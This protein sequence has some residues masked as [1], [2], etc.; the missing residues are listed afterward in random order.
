[1]LLASAATPGLG[2]KAIAEQGTASGAPACTSCHGLHYE[3]NPVVEAPALAGLPAG[4][5]VLRLDHYASPAGK[6]PLMHSVATDLDPAE[7]QAVAAY[8]SSLPK[9]RAGR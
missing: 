1:M 5:I 3:G 2:G 7:R 9:P 8:L 6:N 4:F